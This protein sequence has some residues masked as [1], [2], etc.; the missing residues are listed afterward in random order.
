M[1]RIIQMLSTSLHQ[2]R[3]DL[4]NRSSGVQS[5]GTDIDAVHDTSAAKNTKWIVEIG[6]SL[7]SRSISAISQKT[8]SL[9]QTRGTYEFIRVPPKRG[10]RG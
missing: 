1:I 6:Q 4:A 10:A 2:H 5:L 7:R 9:E 3:P 8:I